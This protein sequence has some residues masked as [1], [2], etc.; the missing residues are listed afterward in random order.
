MKIEIKYESNRAIL[1]LRSKNIDK[2]NIEV[3]RSINI[4][5]TEHRKLHRLRDA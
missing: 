2:L 1:S 4:E 3:L 5:F